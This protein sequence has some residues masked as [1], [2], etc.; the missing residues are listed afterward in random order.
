MIKTY[1]AHPLMIFSFIRPTLIVLFL[2]VIKA[3]EQ[4]L[5]ERN[6]EGV[7]GFSIIVMAS[8]LALAVKSYT[9]QKAKF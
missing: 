2:P 7:T 3:V 6:F 4:Y 5:T 8:I 1:K 9:I